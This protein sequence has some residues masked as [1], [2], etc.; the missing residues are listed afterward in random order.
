MLI[1]PRIIILIM[2]VL[3]LHLLCIQ[4]GNIRHY[5]DQ[6]S[7]EKLIHFLVMC[8]IDSCNS[9]LY[10]LP[11]LQMSKLQRIQNSAA[12]LV[13]RSRTY[14]P[15]AP[16]LQN[17]HW[18]PIRSRI[19]FKILLLTYQCLH[20]TA[21]AYLQD[22]VQQYQPARNLRSKDKYLL[23][24]PAMTTTSYGS[25]SFQSTAVQLWN[26]LPL[27]VKLAETIDQLKTQVKTHLFNQCYHS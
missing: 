23:S 9:L 4:I 25:R 6:K 3:L 27:N 17:L 19:D 21:P 20:G 5:L 13:T 15:V 24:A 16:I 8:R 14:D 26:S 22:L 7:A 10:G 11:D 1:L 18:L 2:F 12:R